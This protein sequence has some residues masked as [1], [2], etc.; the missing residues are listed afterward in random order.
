MVLTWERLVP[1]WN[2]Q[3]Y[4]K[5]KNERTQPSVDLV[6][7]IKIERPQ[8]IIDIGCGPGNSTQ[9]LAERWPDAEITG[10]D[11]SPAMIEKA[12]KD[13]P[14]QEWILGDAARM[15][16]EKRYDIVFSNATIQ[17]LPGHE[18]LIPEF[19]SLVKRGGALAVQVPMFNRMPLNDAI[20]RVAERPEWKAR[21]QG[22][23]DN[24]TY[25]DGD[26]YYRLLAPQAT[27]VE[28]WQTEYI[29]VLPSHPAL[30]EFCR[31]TALRPYLERLPSEKDKSAF[32]GHLLEECQKAYPAQPDG[33]VLFRFKR[34]FFIACNS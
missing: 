20:L 5:F 34:L 29:H 24:F 18:K 1:D 16:T 19:M 33:K 28:L 6:S 27:V 10:L 26:F 4:L 15:D 9:A 22:C 30:I 12:K 31:S 32:E 14:H 7:R 17:W 2:P 23:A 21:M 13:Y 25:H 8:N 3:S 11:N